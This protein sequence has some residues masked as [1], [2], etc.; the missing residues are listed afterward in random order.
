M[1]FL[2][3]LECEVCQKPFIVDDNDVDDD[4]LSCPFCTGDVSVPSDE[5]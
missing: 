4:A 1:E 3:R 5:E 2:L